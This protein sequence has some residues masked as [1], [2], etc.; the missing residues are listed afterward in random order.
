MG[1]TGIVYTGLRYVAAEGADELPLAN[2]L[3]LVKPNDSLLSGNSPWAMSEG[4]IADSKT[5]S[6]FLV[7][8]YEL[9]LIGEA[10]QP[11][12]DKGLDRLRSAL[13]AFQ[14]IKPIQTLGF[15]YHGRSQ[16]SYSFDGSEFLLNRI[17]H[18]P[19]ME[20][21]PW[22]RQHQF[23]SDMLG[24]VPLLIGRLQ[25]VMQGHNAER[26]NAVILLQ[27]GLEN[28]HPYI[29]GLLWVMGLEAIF[30][31]QNR[32]E[33]EDKLCACLG[34]DTLAFPQWDASTIAPTYTVKEV[35]LHL[36]MLR[37]KLAHGVDLRKASIDKTTPVDLLAK[38][39]LLPTSEPTAYSLLLSEAACYLLCQV[40]EKV[41]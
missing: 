25:L 29:A 28:F 31:S 41:L 38:H 3:S 35:A 26:K 40:L 24:K 10:E 21:G 12:L 37:N 19:K 7:C 33:F 4:D 5:A 15:L 1:P 18:R 17:G 13:M 30:D 36:Y 22:A 23:T 39:A 9:P 16:D 14:I 20:P 11:D 2:G 6:R 34:P 27:L 8:H 32:N